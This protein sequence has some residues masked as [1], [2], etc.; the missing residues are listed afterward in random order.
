MAQC[1]ACVPQPDFVA[2]AGVGGIGLHGEHGC[3]ACG[4]LSLM[5]YADAFTG[6]HHTLT[7]SLN[8][9]YNGKSIDAICLI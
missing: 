3:S 1:T 2:D 5:C 8:Q 6:V 4:E 7:L 9:R